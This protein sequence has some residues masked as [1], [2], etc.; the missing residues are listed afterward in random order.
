MNYSVLEAAVLIDYRNGMAVKHIRQKYSIS[1]GCVYKIINS[2]KIERRMKPYQKKKRDVKRRPEKAAQDKLVAEDYLS[3]MLLTDILTKYQFAHFKNIYRA[4]EREGIEINRTK[5]EIPIE[6]RAMVI[7]QF[8]RGT[9]LSSM[10]DANGAPITEWIV[11]RV[12]AEE[13]LVRES[14]RRTC[15]DE[16]IIIAQYNAGALIKRIKDSNDNYVSRCTVDRIRAK[17]NIA[18]RA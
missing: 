4:L 14:K 6:I 13:N 1:V 2:N 10:S 17:H 11:R 12:L 16:A 8:H 3:G 15:H 5:K 18:R 9:A 7:M